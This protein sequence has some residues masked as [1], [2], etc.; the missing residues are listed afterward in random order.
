MVSRFSRNIC[1]AIYTIIAIKSLELVPMI[2]FHLW[3]HNKI[4]ISTHYY[5]GIIRTIDDEWDHSNNLRRIRDGSSLGASRY[6]NP[7]LNF[8]KTIIIIMI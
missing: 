7:S 4:D 1:V 2:P 6:N 3:D 5:D 8:F